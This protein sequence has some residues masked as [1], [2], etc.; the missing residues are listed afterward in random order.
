MHHAA[1]QGGVVMV[2]EVRYDRLVGKSHPQ[3]SVVQFF[4]A[5]PLVGPVEFCPID[6]AVADRWGCLPARQSA[7]EYPPIDGLLATTALQHN[8]T[9]ET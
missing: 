6:A 5:S 7:E 4:R 2:A 1:G 3:K 9:I 8:L